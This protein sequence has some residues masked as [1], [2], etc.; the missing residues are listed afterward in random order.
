MNIRSLLAA[1][2]KRGMSIVLPNAAT[3]EQAG[4]AAAQLSIV[5]ASSL[6]SAAAKEGGEV[7]LVGHLLWVDEELGW[8]TE[9]RI[10]WQGRPH[11]WQLRG[12]T[13]DEAFR[14]GIGGAARILSGNGEG[15]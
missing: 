13:F 14:Q 10:D 7:A 2:A 5:P 3:L 4:I 11:R 1:A 9:W 15:G 8:A 12:V 6:A